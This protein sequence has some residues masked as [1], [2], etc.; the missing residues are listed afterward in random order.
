MDEGGED[1]DE[2]EKQEKRGEYNLIKLKKIY[3]MI[4][5]LN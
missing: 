5:I 1:N 2:I 4:N 3:K